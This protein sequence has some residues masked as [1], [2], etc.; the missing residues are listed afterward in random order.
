MEALIVLG[1]VLFGGYFLY[2]GI[3]HFK[4]LN[5]LTAYAKS[6][7]VPSPNVAVILTGLM[8]ILGGAGIL[9]NQF[10]GLA[11]VLIILFMI[12]TNFIMH[13]FWKKGLDAQNKM[14]D[15][16]SFMKNMALI[17]ALLMMLN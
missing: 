6:K 1:R 17:G 7:G 12:P 4:N 11:V 13:A 14:N 2:S 16:I 3:G 8:L 10:I 5:N 15:Q 9:L